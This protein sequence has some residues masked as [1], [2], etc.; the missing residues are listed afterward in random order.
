[1]QFGRL[2]VT[3]VFSKQNGKKSEIT[4]EG[5]AQIQEFEVKA[6]QYEQN[7]HFFLSHYFRDQYEQAVF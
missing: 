7:K 2:M 4:V 3:S 1:M 5:G 6:D